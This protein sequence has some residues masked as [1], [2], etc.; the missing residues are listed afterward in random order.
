MTSD[1]DTL[2]FDILSLRLASLGIESLALNW[3]TSFFTDRSTAVKIN[4]SISKPSSLLFGIPQGSVLGPLL[5]SI[6]IQP[7]ENIKNNVKTLKFHHYADD[8][9]IYSIT[10]IDSSCNELSS[11]VHLVNRWFL[12]NRLLLNMTKTQLLNLM[13]L[14]FNILL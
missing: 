12:S 2:S 3:L 8:I 4:D 11:C 14:P 7:I 13:Y 10:N 1:F 5:F 6:Y 9:M